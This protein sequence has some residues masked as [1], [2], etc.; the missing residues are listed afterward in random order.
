MPL[1]CVQILNEAVLGRTNDSTRCDICEILGMEAQRYNDTKRHVKHICMPCPNL[2]RIAKQKEDTMASPQL[3]P[4][5]AIRPSAGRPPINDIL[6]VNL[7]ACPV[8]GRS[9]GPSGGRIPAGGSS[10]RSE[11]PRS[12]EGR[13]RRCRRRCCRRFPGWFGCCL[14]KKMRRDGARASEVL[15]P[16]LLVASDFAPVPAK[17]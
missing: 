12:R 11:P 4:K 1:R 13:G 14:L 10:L 16:D 6:H 5:D 3:P 17:E 15:V 8:R 9:S 2:H 7:P